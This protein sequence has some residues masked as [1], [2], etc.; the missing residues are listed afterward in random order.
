MLR[1]TVI[2]VLP[3]NNYNLLLEFD[4]GEKKYFDVKPYIKG[5]W[6][7]EL[8]NITYFNRVHTNGFNVEWPNGQDICPDDLYYKSVDNL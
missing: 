6:F 7:N 3:E 2:N 5:S 1:P 4:N 8:N